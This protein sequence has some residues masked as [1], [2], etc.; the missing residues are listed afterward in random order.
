MEKVPFNHLVLMTL[1]HV[2][3]VVAIGESLLTRRMQFFACLCGACE[4]STIFLNNL[5]LSREI[6]VG[7]KEL[8]DVL[9]H[10]FV[11]V[12][13][14]GLWLAF[15]FFRLCLFPYWLYIMYSDVADFPAATWD[16]A[17]MVERYMYPGVT[18]FLLCLSTF[19][20]IPIT[21]G[22]LKALG[23]IKKQPK[24]AAQSGRE[25]AQDEN[26]AGHWKQG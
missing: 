17:N 12:N 23:V 8:K 13:G 11:C 14:M 22:L 7:G 21:K 24:D 20:F 16:K 15:L 3:S 10:A 5:Y 18:V 25:G 26:G 2:L 1:H 6:T 9:P 4:V 19:W